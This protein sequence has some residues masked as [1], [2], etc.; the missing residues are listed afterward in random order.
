MAASPFSLRQRQIGTIERILNLNHD[1]VRTTEFGNELASS[2]GLITHSAPLLN[3]DGDP[4][5]KVLVFDDLGRDVISSVL[6]V[7]DLRSWGVTIH[8]NI[9]SR[10]YPIPDVP[11]LYLVEPTA[12][13]L[14]AVT[15][16]L[17]KGLYAP[18][19]VN[20][21]SSVPRPFLEDFASQIASTGT[22]EK[23]AQVY[24]QYLN[25]IVAEPELFSLG[26]SK[27]TYWKIN[28][29]QTKDEELD[30]LVDK[31]VSGL[32]SVSVT[33][34]AI[35]II[36]CPKGGAAELI[37]TKLDRKLRDH[38]LN[39]KDNLFTA[40]NQRGLGVP[41]ARPVLIIADRNVDL[42]PM[43][44]HSWTYQSLVHDVLTM[45]LNRITL[46]TPIDESSPDKGT[47][48]RSY[49]LAANDFFWVRNAGVPFPQVA[50]DIDTELTR[51]KEDATDIT[52][53]TG[54]SSIED[55]Q[56][57]TASSAQHL[58]AAITLLPE[59]RERKAVLDM[60][61][62]IATSLLKGIKDR[63]LDNFFQL[64]ENISKQSKQQILEILA[65][66]NRGNNPT[67]K[68]RLFLIW[69]LS[70]ESDL[71]RAE[72]GRFEEALMQAGCKDIS[73]LAYVKRV[74]EITRMTM[75]TTSTTTP[76]QPSS[77]L[78]KGFSSLSNRLTDRIASGALGANFDS[79]ISGVKNFLP[80]NKDLTLTKITESIMD[81]SSAS[82]S[83]I[84]KTEN[85]LYFD[86]R[87]A[88]A[89]GA[90][91]PSAAS[92][93]NAAQAGVSS[94]LG[95]LA[96]GSTATFGQRRQGF[97]EAI[98]FTVGGGSMEEYGNLQDWVRRTGGAETSGGGAGGGS[99]GTSTAT[100]GTLRRRV[101]YG[102]TELLNAGDFLREALEPLGKES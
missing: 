32:F 100:N 83:A 52:K 51:Y 36:R 90:I 7:N 74:R 37:A 61:M 85:Y 5:W 68:L 23:I 42:V 46:E 14:Q 94:S 18:A 6:R 98:V 80:V 38:I 21:L 8:L 72:L 102:S 28:S 53:K 76:Q 65:D 41:T 39:S 91:P 70:I 43:L 44:S 60:H 25:F 101:V 59:L 20:F 54:A 2:N 92:S 73:S 62:N 12:E 67:D 17:S 55:L 63:Q 9:K 19:Y 84:A 40:G 79:L 47:V 13:N 22:S 71:S 45:H 3:E 58:K 95:S 86:P 96:P 49:D 57:D 15:S 77:D 64:E 78:F 26:M 75:M 29:A 56:N 31:I 27:D 88:N 81:P 99:G 24:D 89:R 93:R 69:F 11:V 30:I 34:G 87:S 16:D 4:V 97:N 33:M 50:E 35:P 66:P 10:R 1:P 48:K 82:S